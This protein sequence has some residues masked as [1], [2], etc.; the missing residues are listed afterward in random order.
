MPEDLQMVMQ[1]K[2]QMTNSYTF[3]GKCTLNLGTIVLQQFELKASKSLTLCIVKLEDTEYY[4]NF[5]YLRIVIRKYSVVMGLLTICTIFF[6]RHISG[7]DLLVC[8]DYVY[9]H[10][11]DCQDSNYYLAPDK[12]NDII[13]LPAEKVSSPFQFVFPFFLYMKIIP[14]IRNIRK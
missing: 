7:S 14:V 13:A 8:G 12:I 4:D 9:N 11:H 1:A 10:Y 3:L 2:G 5:S 6:P